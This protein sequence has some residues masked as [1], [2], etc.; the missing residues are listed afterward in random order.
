MRSRGSLDDFAGI[1]WPEQAAAAEPAPPAIAACKA[2]HNASLTGG[3]SAS[4]IAPRLAGQ[5]APYLIDTMA[6]Y[7]DGERANSTQM[8]ALMRKPAAGGSQ[9]GRQLLGRP[10][11]ILEAEHSRG[12][13]RNPEG[14]L[15]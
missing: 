13:L 11:L 8:S 12:R 2:C 15:Q 14:S 1:E 5:M 6:A 9:S 3:M 7:A 10:A 4:G